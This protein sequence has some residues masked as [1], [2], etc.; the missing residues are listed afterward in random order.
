MM[1][2]QNDTEA[3]LKGLLLANCVAIKSQ[4]NDIYT[5]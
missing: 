5:L 1:T 3:S 2:L 4:V